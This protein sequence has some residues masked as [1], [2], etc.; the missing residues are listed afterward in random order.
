MF[1]VLHS[2][3]TVI[4]LVVKTFHF[5]VY[6]PTL[7]TRSENGKKINVYSLLTHTKHKTYPTLLYLNC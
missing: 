4:V 2:V 1:T 6:R 7:F 3:V 5:S